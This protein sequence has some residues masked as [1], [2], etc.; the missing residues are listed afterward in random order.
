[1][2][3]AT[4]GAWTLGLAL[5]VAVAVAAGTD[6]GRRFVSEDKVTDLEHAR[7]RRWRQSSA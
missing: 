6:L 1:M 5:A 2:R 7:T 3:A 4:T